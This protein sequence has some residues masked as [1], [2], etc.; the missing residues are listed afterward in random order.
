MPLQ[1]TYRPKTLDEIVGNVDMVNSIKT[2]F[3]REKDLPHA[4]LFMGPKGSGKST[5]GRIVAE[6]LLGMPIDECP[7]FYQIDGGDVKADTIKELKRSISYKPSV[8]KCRVWLI[9]ECFPAGTM[10][11]TPSGNIPIEQIKVDQDIVSLYGKDKV[12]AVSQNK[13]SFDRLIK[14]TFSEDRNIYT[15]K[16]HLFFTS[17]GWV[18][19]QNLTSD[20]I[21]YPLDSEFIGITNERNQI[22]RDVQQSNSEMAEI[23]LQRMSQ[24]INDKISVFMFDMRQACQKIGESILWEEMCQREFAAASRIQSDMQYRTSQKKTQQERSKSLEKYV[25]RNERLYRRETFQANEKEKSHVQFRVC[26]KNEIYKRDKWNI[27]PVP[28]SS[29]REWGVHKATSLIV[30]SIELA[31]GSCYSAW[32][33]ISW[34][35]NLLQSRYWQQETEACNRSRWKESRC[36][37]NYIERYKENSKTKG[38]RL[39]NS[40]IYKRGNNDECFQSIIGDKEKD[41]GYVICYDLQVKNHPSYFANGLPVHNCHMIGSGGASEK[42]IPQNNFLTTLEEPPPWVYFILCTTD[43]QR[44]IGTIHSRCH[45]FKVNPLNDTEMKTLLLRTL[46]KEDVGSFPDKAIQAIIDTA[47]GCPRDALKILDQVIDLEDEAIITAI[48]SFTPLEAEIKDLCQSLANG[49]SWARIKDIIY[50]I[51]QKGEDA[52]NVR[53]A[54]IGYITKIALSSDQKKKKRGDE[55]P[56]I[57]LTDVYEAL[58]TVT[59]ANGWGDIVFPLYQLSAG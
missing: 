30:K 5:T 59:Y 11:E 53:R 16:D 15:T 40:E 3:S 19:A 31:Y 29:W 45:T 9:E 55:D 25:S 49:E 22:L 2:I 28:C 56:M 33:K 18:E 21:I 17:K 51:K 1:T 8:A 10:I 34:L 32:W 26:R 46:K 23:L 50:K 36:E 6:K 7:D 58:K 38:I 14:L 41:Q 24:F 54:V 37:K 44:L 4:W 52:E 12:V 39:A 43:P 27:A 42:N 13:I 47:D 35:S 57:R 20:D 48:N